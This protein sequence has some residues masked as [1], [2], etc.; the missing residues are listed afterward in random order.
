[1]QTIAKSI[2]VPDQYREADRARRI[3]M[4]ANSFA[5]HLGRPLVEPG[6]DVVAAMWSAPFAILAHGTQADPL[7]YFANLYA[8]NLFEYDVATILQTPSRLSAEELVRAERQA[9][10]DRVQQDGF[11]DDYAGVRI[12]ASGRRFRIER[13]VVWNVIDEAGQ[14][15]G[16]AATFRV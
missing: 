11:I 8:L 3:A 16:Q 13:A 6:D 14:R 7:F 1:M 10:L 12:S 4:A 5:A 2:S 15:H 9:L